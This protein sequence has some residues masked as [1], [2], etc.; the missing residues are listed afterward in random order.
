MFLLK[1][2]SPSLFNS[3]PTGEIKKL[4][5]K[6]LVANNIEQVKLF[7]VP[8][9]GAVYKAQMRGKPISHYAP[10]SGAGRVYKRIAKEIVN[11]T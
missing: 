5:R 2:Y 6:F 4:V 7:T 1:G 11:Y 9:S 8:F 3:G 10:Y